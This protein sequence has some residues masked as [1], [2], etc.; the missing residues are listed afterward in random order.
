MVGK[1]ATLAA[2]CCKPPEECGQVKM[3]EVS[4]GYRSKF[5][6]GSFPDDDKPSGQAMPVI[7]RENW[8]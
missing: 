6:R 8:R 7:L 3:D 5:G 4:M 2:Q 1:T